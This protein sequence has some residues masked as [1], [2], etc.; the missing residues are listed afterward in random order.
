MKAAVFREAGRPL[1]IEEIP[2][3]APA[4]GEALL[5]SRGGV[6]DEPPGGERAEQIGHSG[7]SYPLERG[8]ATG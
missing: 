2:T 1:A 5:E 3:P 7:V 6:V 4:P 8:P